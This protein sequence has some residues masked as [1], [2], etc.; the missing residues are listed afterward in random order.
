MI[1]IAVLY[2]KSVKEKTAVTQIQLKIDKTTDV[3]GNAQKSKKLF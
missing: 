1:T 3:K 2:V